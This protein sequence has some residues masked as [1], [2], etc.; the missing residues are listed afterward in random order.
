MFWRVVV[1]RRIRTVANLAFGGHDSWSDM[2]ISLSTIKAAGAIATSVAGMTLMLAADANAALVKTIC[3]NPMLPTHT[4]QYSVTIDD[5][6]G[7][8]AT[9][10]AYGD[11]NL[12]DQNDA[13]TALVNPTTDPDWT[14][15]GQNSAFSSSGPL[16]GGKSGDWTILNF[17]PSLEYAI[18]VK[19]GGAPK[20][21]VFLIPQGV[22]TGFWGVESQQ[23]GLSHLALY[24]RQGEEPTPGEE[25]VVPEPASIALLGLGL[26]AVGARLR[27]RAA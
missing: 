7:G 26:V 17:D 21:A 18:G 20:W 22:S 19:N 25:P 5:S 24:S 23:G 16:N 9:C 13:F 10:L 27:R 6:V 3:P 14:F 12:A 15:V 2:K 1:A 4:R 11:G 8:A